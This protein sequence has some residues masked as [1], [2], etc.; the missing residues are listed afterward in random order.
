MSASDRANGAQAIEDIISQLVAQGNTQLANTYIFGGTKANQAPFE[1]NPDY[2]VNYKVPLAAQEPTNAYVGQG[3]LSPTGFSA[4]GL[5]YS[6]NKVLYENPANSYTGNTYS[7]ASSYAFVIDSKNNTLY[8]NGSPVTLDAGIYQGSEL[9]SQIQSQLGSGY[10][11]TFDS[12]TGS[13]AIQN[14]TGQAVHPQLVQSGR[15]CRG[16][17]RLR[18]S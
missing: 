13:F 14:N 12:T 2:S 6:T 18:P 11:V 4:Q 1:L 15:H 17:P 9:A 8:V 5:F 3:E 16:N 10:Y 7:D